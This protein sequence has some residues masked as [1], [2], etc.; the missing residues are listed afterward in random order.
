MV[1][2]S[3]YTN[4]PQIRDIPRKQSFLLEYL[5]SGW[6]ALVAAVINE[7]FAYI[8]KPYTTRANFKLI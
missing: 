3:L 2:Y 7:L 4:V 1:L 8:I 6:L 5:G